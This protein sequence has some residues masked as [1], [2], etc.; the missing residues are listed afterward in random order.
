MERSRLRSNLK[1]KAYHNLFLAFFGVVIIVAVLFFF[2]TKILIGFSLLS[3]KLSGTDATNSTIQSNDSSYVSPPSLDPVVDATN[4]AQIVVTGIASAQQTIHLYVN[5]ELVDKTPVRDDNHFKF[6]SVTL[7]E[8][9][10]MIKALAVTSSK[11]K[12]DYS[13]ELQIN[14]LKK[15]PTLT[16][17]QPQD[18]QGFKKDPGTESI[19]GQTDPGVQVTVNDFVAIVDA[20]GKFSYLYTLKD[21]DNDLKIKATDDAHNETVKEMHI[22]TE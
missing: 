11:K 6:A 14:F 2:G 17:N 18:G 4:S 21:G 7:K 12:S 22:H 13:A 19:I 1:T 5:G 16:I 3:E 10:N 20:Q 15:S 8:G 9:Q